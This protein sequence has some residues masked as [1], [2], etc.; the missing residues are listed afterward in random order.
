MILVFG[1]IKNNI[2]QK[3]P[4]VWTW[5]HYLDICLSLFLPF[6]KSKSEAY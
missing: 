3:D 6:S 5:A 4:A 2:K 1:I